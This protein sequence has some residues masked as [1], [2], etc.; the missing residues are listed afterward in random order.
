V[1]DQME[2]PVRVWSGLVTDEL[3]DLAKRG[4]LADVAR[5]AYLWGGP[6]LHTMVR[7]GASRSRG[8]LSIVALPS[9]SGGKSTIVPPPEAIS[10]S[11]CDV[12]VIVTEHGVADLRGANPAER[13]TRIA[14][15]ADPRSRS[16]LLSGR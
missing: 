16:A 5:S 4:L 1:V 3:V 15:I 8:G 13:A 9:M 14:A 11:R 12:D 10:T 2:K 6:A 7:R